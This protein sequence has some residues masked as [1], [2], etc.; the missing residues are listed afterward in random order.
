MWDHRDMPSTLRIYLPGPEGG[1]DARSSLGAAAR[2]LKFVHKVEVASGE[3]PVKWLFEKTERGSLVVDAVPDGVAERSVEAVIDGL[4]E[5]D[6][7]EA[8][9]E[10]WGDRKLVEDAY[11]LAKTLISE[12]FS[13]ARFEWL[14]DGEVVKRAEINGRVRDHLEA[15]V[16][17]KHVSIGS[18]VGQ[19]GT[20]SLHKKLSATMWT[21]LSDTA[22]KLRFDKSMVDAIRKSLGR[23]VEAQGRI[24]RNWLDQPVDIKLRKLVPL[25]E[26]EDLP[27][28]D[29]YHGRYP[30]FA[31]GMDSSE[32]VRR[33]RDAS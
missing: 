10:A 5:A 9:P 15:L 2:M 24:T 33:M 11:S 4:V 17:V 1:M 27:N 23:R 12:D 8:V 28:L 21:D 22:V 14:V 30:D 25:P 6:R 18:V 32:F 26:I 3:R 7:R 19:L 13:G 20:A 16:D 31:G 29:Y